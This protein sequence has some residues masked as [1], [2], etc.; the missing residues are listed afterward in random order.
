MNIVIFGSSGYVGRSLVP[1]L[2]DVGHSL[3]VVNR[4]DYYIP[5]IKSII[6]ESLFDVH[7][8]YH[9]L[10][11]ADVVVYLSG[12]AHIT[13]KSNFSNLSDYLTS[14]YYP[15]TLVAQL[16]GSLGI[17]RFIFFS[18]SKVLGEFTE[19]GTFFSNSS[20]PN[21]CNSYSLSK[22]L[23]ERFL[24]SLSGLY[25]TDFVSVRPPLI[26]GQTPKGNI[27]TLFKYLHNSIPIPILSLSNNRRS[28]LSL[29][30]LN[31]FIERIIEHPSPINSSL[32]ISDGK[33]YST[34]DF[35][36][37]ISKIYGFRPLI[38]YCPSLILS[39][40]FR[41]LKPNLFYTL[42]CSFRLDISSTCELL[43]FE[44]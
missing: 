21:P 32:L 26:Y 23:S 17:R 18:T 10:L 15:L 24:T 27:L 12:L 28:I 20:T 34:L 16:C 14:N 38:F 25:S 7:L 11:S 8:Y 36:M 1:F 35:V 13:N 44:P 4:S 39:F 43:G 2:S 33:D 37:H 3:T 31:L 40:L 19:P 22:Y 6:V 29:D 41:F 5:N 30:N 42:I 9:E